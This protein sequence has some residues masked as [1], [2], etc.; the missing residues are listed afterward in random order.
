MPFNKTIL[1]EIPDLIDHIYQLSKDE[2]PG[3]IIQNF[4]NLLDRYGVDMKF[5]QASE[6]FSDADTSGWMPIQTLFRKYGFL[7]MDSMAQKDQGLLEKYLEPA[8]Q[9]L[10][11]ALEKAELRQELTRVNRT[12]E[13]DQQI[14][15]S[16]KDGYEGLIR[17]VIENSPIGISIREKNGQLLIVNRAW[18]EIWAIPDEDLAQYFEPREQF[19]LDQRD[20]YLGEHAAGVREVY[21]NGGEYHIPEMRLHKNRPGKATWISQYFY[22][23]YGR[24]GE[25]SKIVVLTTDISRRKKSE[26][27]ITHHLMLEEAIARAS[28]LFASGDTPDFPQLMKLMGTT[29]KASRVT[30]VSLDDNVTDFPGGSTWMN[31][32]QPMVDSIFFPSRQNELGHRIMDRFRQSEAVIIRSSKNVPASDTVM[33]EWF[34]K[35]EL[36]AL[37]AV[38]VLFRE[39]PHSYLVVEDHLSSRKW[40]EHEQRVLI[41]ISELLSVFLERQ[42]ASRA[43]RENEERI[44]KVLKILPVGV[45]ITDKKGNVVSD[46]LAS[47]RIWAVPELNNSLDDFE[48]DGWFLDSG[49]KIEPHEWASAKACESGITTL[50]EPVQIHSQDGESKII[51]NSAVPLMNDRNEIEGAVVIGN[52]ITRQKRNESELEKYRD[53]LEEMVKERSLEL[54]EKQAQ[55]VH[56]SRLASLGEMA[57][58]VAHE[59][60]QPL[61]II[62]AQVELL[63][64]QFRNMKNIPETTMNDMDLILN[65]VRRASDIITHMRN[66]SRKSSSPTDRINLIQPVRESLVFFQQQFKVHNIKLNIEIQDHLPLVLVNPQEF[67]QIVV[68]F[69]S[70]ARFAVESKRKQG[71]ITAYSPEIGLH[72]FHHEGSPFAVFEVTDNGIGMSESAKQRCLEPFFTT[73]EVGEGTGLGLS[74]VHGI[75]KE[76]NGVIEVESELDKGTTLR[77]KIPSAETG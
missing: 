31:P 33:V 2:E 15:G 7:T 44:R 75:V 55:L 58:G 9:V 26:K 66:F 51:L 46:N 4:I 45:W 56:S 77:V 54:Q 19:R 64:L 29:M 41:V 17:V 69:M 71:K 37:M 11:I 57:T 49:K 38:P 25:V 1:K 30:I 72:L 50:N 12:L 60:N 53:H 67:Q 32:D 13:M 65:Q 73:K 63:K 40:Y 22:A 6:L 8:V 39:K 5:R 20:S 76:F 59:L 68:N 48:Y 34:R 21:E 28:R 3:Q 10:R 43:L 27:I 61:A 36:R 47:R 62:Q 24:D 52:D 74:I 14:S 35:T 23:L 42:E 18:R 16:I 70:N